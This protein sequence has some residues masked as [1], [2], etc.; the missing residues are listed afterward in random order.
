MAKFSIPKSPQTVQDI[1]VNGWNLGRSTY[2]PLIPL[3]FLMGI[4]YAVQGYAHHMGA[5]E[6]NAYQANIFT[7]I[8]DLIVLCINVCLMASVIS[9]LNQLIEGKMLDLNRDILFGFSKIKII[10]P[11]ALLYGICVVIGFILLV[12]PGVFIAVLLYFSLYNAVLRNT[13]IIDSFRRSKDLVLRQWFHTAAVVVGVIVAVAILNVLLLAPF[14][15]WPLVQAVAEILFYALVMPMFYAI[16][17]VLFFDL[18]LRLSKSPSSPSST[19]SSTK[20]E[21]M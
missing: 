14:K 4:A 21:K 9:R 2:E 8:I 6:G 17:L 16:S 15:N 10:L 7:F 13:G 18:E 3:T 1:F 19:S 5:G 11:V 20:I 12:L